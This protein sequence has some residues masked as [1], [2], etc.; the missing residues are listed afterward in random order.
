MPDATQPT[1]D[2]AALIDALAQAAFVTMGALTRIAADNDLSLTQLRALA[3]LRDRRLRMTDLVEY[4]GLEK[5]TLTGLISRAEARG[6]VHR[7]PHP[8][9]R[10]ATE[11]F[12]STHGHTLAAA[13]EAELAAS[14][15]PVMEKLDPAEQH[16]L[17]HLLA[18]AVATASTRT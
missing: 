8:V 4:L 11:V 5:S 16:T 2:T 6:L 18:K 15:A 1:S 9:D 3:I 10:R 14:L 12:L 7:A 17:A 13:L